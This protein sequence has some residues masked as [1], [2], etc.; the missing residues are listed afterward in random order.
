MKGIIDI[1]NE[2]DRCSCSLCLTRLS[3][4]DEQFNNTVDLKEIQI[5]SLCI[6]LCRKCRK[7]LVKTIIEDMQKY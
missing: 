6:C 7:S 2:N 5:G 4:D 1:R 3:D